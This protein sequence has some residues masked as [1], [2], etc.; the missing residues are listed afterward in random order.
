MRVY[1]KIL[2]H[3]VRFWMTV[4]TERH[5]QTMQITQPVLAEVGISLVLF[6]ECIYYISFLIRYLLVMSQYLQK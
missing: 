6:P 3:Y 2:M 4:K 5:P 1:F